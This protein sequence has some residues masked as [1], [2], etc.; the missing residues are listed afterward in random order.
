[1][2]K[3]I[4][5]SDV[6]KILILIFCLVNISALFFLLRQESRSE[7]VNSVISYNLP[8]EEEE[9]KEAPHAAYPLLILDESLIPDLT[10]DDLYNLKDVLIEA[11]ALSAEDGQ[12]ND[13]SDQIE[14]TLMPV[15]G[16][17]GTFDA[18]F[19]IQN[20]QR[21]ISAA[22]TTISV[23]LTA[24]FL[25][26]TDDHIKIDSYSDFSISPYIEI[27]IDVDGD[28]LTEYV[29]TDDYVNTASTG[30]YNITIYVYSRE[31][32]SMTRK[33]LTVTVR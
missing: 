3:K 15:E 14:W 10:E 26:L 22:A 13:I 9:E 33:D 19:S 31:V 4:E 25:K 12:G 5:S 6:I 11:Q 28:D 24:P 32:D 18:S 1:M 23:E 29:A 16:Q 17:A 20:D 2:K 8:E 30:T 21:R 7:N 27:A